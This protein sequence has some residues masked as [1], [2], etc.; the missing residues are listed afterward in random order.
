MPILFTRVDLLDEI[1]DRELTTLV[2]RV[3][4]EGD[5]DPE[6]AA[7]ARAQ[8][9]LE[10]HTARYAL[11]DATQKDFLRDLALYYLCARV[12]DVPPNRQSAY[13]E[14]MRELRDIR[15]GKYPDLPLV[16]AEDETSAW[17]RRE[18]FCR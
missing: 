5:A 9:T 7:I 17:G 10:R 6:A 14:T 16:S 8:S 13:D 4:H 2:S 11:D 15:D 12:A 1:N 18:P 3:L